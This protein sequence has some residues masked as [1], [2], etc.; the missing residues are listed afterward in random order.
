MLK[1]QKYPRDGVEKEIE[2]G[3]RVEVATTEPS[4]GR[5]GRG[6]LLIIGRESIEALV[7]CAMGFGQTRR[8]HCI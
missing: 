3:M 5:I 1:G 6:N 7:Q 2:W 4:N 8:I